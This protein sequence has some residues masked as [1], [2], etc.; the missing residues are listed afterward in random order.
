MEGTA[1][2]A[3]F[4]APARDIAP[5]RSPTSP[6]IADDQSVDGAAAFLVRLRPPPW[7]LTAIRPDGPITTFTAHAEAQARAFT[8]RY[9][10]KH[11]LYYS[12]NPTR[13]PV[14]KKA[15]K[16]DIA[17]AE[18][19]YADCDPRKAEAPSDA[20]TRIL[21]TLKASGLP[22]PTFI[23]DSGNGLQLL[24]R[25]DKATALPSA[26]DPT[27]ARI[28]ADIEGRNKA[29][30]AAMGADFET[31][32]I[33]R[34]LRLPCTTNLPTKAKLRKGRVPC[35]SVLM[36]YKDISYTLADLPEPLDETD[37]NSASSGREQSGK[38][39]CASGSMP[40]GTE[41]K[42]S[43]HIKR[44]ITTGTW[45]P[46]ERYASRSEA[47]F[48]V[49]C[50]LV[51]AGYQDTV[52]V[53]FISDP[54]FP[55][56]EHVR[57]QKNSARYARQQVANARKTV[58]GDTPRYRKDE[59]GLSIKHWNARTRQEC[60]LWVAAP[61]EILGLCR[62]PR[63][64]SWGKLLA[65]RDEDGLEHTHVAADAE[66][67][68]EPAEVCRPLV[69]GGLK[70]DRER[71]RDFANYLS[72]ARPTER[73]TIVHRTGWHWIEGR[74]CFALPG[75]T[76]GEVGQRVVLAAAARGPYEA[77]GTIE[78]WRDAVAKPASA[79]RLAVLA[80]STALAGPLLGFAGFEGGGIHFYG[81]SSE[82][83]TTLLRI[84]ASVWGQGDGEHGYLRTW[85][86][87]AN[88]LE[89]AAAG[90]TDTALILDELSQ[91]DARDM[92]EAAYL[93]AN[94]EGKSRANRDGSLREPATWRVMLLS[95][96]E[97]PIDAK[98]AEESG[99]RARAGQL[100]RILDIPLAGG[101]GA[102][103]SP[104]ENGSAA[105]AGEF[106]RATTEAYG[107]A[108][109]EFVRRLIVDGLTGE[110]VRSLANQFA[111]LQ[112]PARRSA[113]GQVI[114]ATQRL[115]LIAAAG[116]LA[117]Q[118]GLTGWNKGAATEAAASALAAWIEGRGGTE[119]A[120]ERQAISQ[121]RLFIEEHGETRFDGLTMVS[122]APARNRVGWRDGAGET[123]KWLIPPETFASIVCKGLDP[124]LVARVL[125][126]RGMIDKG[127]DQIAQ[128]RWIKGA[129][130]RVIVVTH[131]IFSGADEKADDEPRP[132]TEEEDRL[133]R[134]AK[135]DLPDSGVIKGP[136]SQ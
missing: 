83:K 19:L 125:A 17:A 66:L 29:L 132:L 99:R 61:F 71:Q 9:N 105:L 40:N 103:D 38:A 33:D 2:S 129:S 12:P 8:A 74:R 43:D 96:G 20:K 10:G 109:P 75:A 7:V 82:G 120:E 54:Q 131:R 126:K 108:G 87:T 69:S 48:A 42:V 95:S 113:D 134:E 46:P 53:H 18:Y 44:L 93:L 28:V 64:N 62:D 58:G 35:A 79:H 127:K 106:R 86:A 5:E 81:P 91:I 14:R 16:T 76:V 77:R 67:C 22:D 128:V 121:V 119:P 90:A 133:Y 27:W 23:V 88:G 94:G 78:Q 50:A 37:L 104:G 47:V 85:R 112:V 92:A 84:G 63:G 73:V 107:T 122:E 101:Y 80:I 111:D 102:F 24:W 30:L 13:T 32:N 3:Q 118:F 123:Q 136:W 68:G 65:W 36:S 1:M 100:V 41:L 6:R 51:R 114:R 89:G 72:A 45:T 26:G 115:G 52:V 39:E 59:H 130:K 60:W 98:I 97:L 116:E 49:A 4:E 21:A 135:G 31:R 11:N 124:K 70:I 110:H 117:T 15:E 34:I 57:D 55:I 56:S 25:L